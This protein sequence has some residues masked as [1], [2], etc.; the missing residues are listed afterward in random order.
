MKVRRY[1]DYVFEAKK[2]T[3]MDESEV[4]KLLNESLNDKIQMYL[5]GRILCR[6]ILFIGG[7]G[8]DFLSELTLY[9]TNFTYVADDFLFMEKDRAE[10][11]Y[12]II[13]GKVAMIH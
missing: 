12:F 10:Y 9:F 4:F 11:I 5:R 2:E 7:F 1:L 13:Q 3:K 6:I 8:L